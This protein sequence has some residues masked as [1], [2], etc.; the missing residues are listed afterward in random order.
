MA[1]K[2]FADLPT[3]ESLQQ[4]A[5]LKCDTFAPIAAD[6]NWFLEATNFGGA[7]NESDTVLAASLT[8]AYCP[9]RP[10]VPVA[11]VTDNADDDWTGVSVTISGVG[12]FGLPVLETKAATNSSGT[13]TATFNNAFAS[14]ISV[15]IAVTGTTTASDSYIIGFA[16][17]YGLGVQISAT[18]DVICSTFNGAADAGTISA[19]YHTYLIAGTPDAAK[20]FS[21]AIRV[22]QIC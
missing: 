19:T 11:V 9:E 12:Q 21:T 13:W 15:T 17:T 10:V 22:P 16:K 8:R 18:T 7:E 6:D 14:I 3:R 20:F 5:G 1:I 2:K 4:F